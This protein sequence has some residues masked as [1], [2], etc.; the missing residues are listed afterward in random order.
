MFTIKVNKKV[1][2]TQSLFFNHTKNVSETDPDEIR[3]T[4]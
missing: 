4:C 1:Y 3:T 2:P